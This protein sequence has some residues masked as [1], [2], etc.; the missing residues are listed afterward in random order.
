VPGRFRL[1]LKP[2]DPI[3]RQRASAST[4]KGTLFLNYWTCKYTDKGYMSKYPIDLK[5]AFIETKWLYGE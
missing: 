5:A 1:H 2:E 4:I 3:F